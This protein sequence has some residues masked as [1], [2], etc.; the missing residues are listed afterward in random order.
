MQV[1]GKTLKVPCLACF[2]SD[3]LE[4]TAVVARVKRKT[5]FFGKKR[6]QLVAICVSPGTLSPG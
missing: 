2:Q 1:T 6:S 4:Q 3:P 5:S